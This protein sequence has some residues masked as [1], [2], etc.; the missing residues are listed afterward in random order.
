MRKHGFRLFPILLVLPMLV[1]AAWSQGKRQNKNVSGNYGSPKVEIIFTTHE[2]DLI[3]DWFWKNRK[4]L[5]PG[6]AKRDSLPPGLQKQLQRN[7]T[8]PPG[9]QKKLT[10]LPY[11]LDSMLIKLPGDYL[12]VVIG[13]D[14]VLLNRK[15]NAILDIISYVIRDPD[16]K[17]YRRP[18]D[19]RRES[20]GDDYEAGNSDRNRDRD[21]DDNDSEVYQARASAPAPT[22]ST[23][24]NNTPVAS[25]KV[26]SS[27][28]SPTAQ[29]SF[30]LKVRM[31]QPLSTDTAKVGDRFVVTLDEEVYDGNRLAA[32]KGAQAEG[33]VVEVDQ[34]GRVKGFASITVKLLRFQLTSGKYAE[35]NSDPVVVNANATK[36]EDATKIALTTG[37]GT[38][39]GALVGG[40]KGAVVGAVTGA[41]AG[42]GVVLATRG[43]PAVIPSESVL[44]FA[45]RSN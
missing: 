8:L 44:E 2:R 1:T 33:Q 4:G 34:G 40:G 26:I 36:G 24:P 42:T 12:R 5:P 32:R 37:I 38:G 35:I 7:G 28:S 15:N 22:A 6:L 45:I 39:I 13:R 25:G 31:T 29:Q 9:L 14:V 10:P 30:P 23:A 19:R 18:D 17:E 11:S 41:G 16:E 3:S 27:T 21:R 43:D 20:D